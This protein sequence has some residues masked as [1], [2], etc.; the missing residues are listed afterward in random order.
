RGGAPHAPA[1]EFAI[2]AFEAQPGSIQAGESTVLR[3]SVRGAQ[4]VTITPDLG[5]VA[6]NGERTVSPRGGT[7]YTLTAVS[8]NDTQTRR[9]NIA[10]APVGAA[11]AA[12]PSRTPPSKTMTWSVV[13]DHSGLTGA[14]KGV[15]PFGNRRRSTTE[16]PCLGV[17]TVAG[18][19]VRFQ[20]STSTD[21]FDRPLSSIQEIRTNR[22]GLGGKHPF[23]IR[24]D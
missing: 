8:P 4:R 19:H 2:D 14:I 21:S 12:P 7:I 20:S 3:W 10:V 16:E 22:L 24:F 17:L 15:A 13:H 5:P 1:A 23:H 9:V 18:G 11:G 6:A